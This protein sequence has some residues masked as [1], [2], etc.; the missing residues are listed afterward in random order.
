MCILRPP[1]KILERRPTDFMHKLFT[2]LQKASAQE[3]KIV[4]VYNSACHP[5]A[6]ESEVCFIIC[7]NTFGFTQN[8][9]EGFKN[10][11]C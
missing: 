10:I 2:K 5:Q 8:N 4:N 6:I 3:K 9:L 1:E 11:F 7:L